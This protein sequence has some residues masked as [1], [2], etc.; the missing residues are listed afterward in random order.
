M[1][2]WLTIE[3]V[4]G[5]LLVTSFTCVGLLSLWAATSLRHWFAQIEPE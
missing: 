4:L 3:L 1:R 2:D 5:V